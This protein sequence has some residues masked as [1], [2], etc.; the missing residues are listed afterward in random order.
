MTNVSRATVEETDQ[1]LTGDPDT[2]AQDERV[3]HP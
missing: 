2:T 3:A 1:I